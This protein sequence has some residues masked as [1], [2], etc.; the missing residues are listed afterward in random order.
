MG[1]SGVNTAL[2]GTVFT[3]FTVAGIAIAALNAFLWKIFRLWNLPISYALLAIGYVFCIIG[4]NTGSIVWFFV[5]SVIIGIGCCLCGMVLPMIMSVTVPAAALTLAIGFQ[6]V[7]RNLGS[8]LSS[9]WLQAVG[10]V[11]GDVPIPQFTAICILSIVVTVGA[12]VAAARDNKK[13]KDVEL[14]K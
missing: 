11:F 6:E 9:P 5:A 10:G 3:I 13:F 2:I 12:A 7:A 1:M 14:Q 4:F 8:F